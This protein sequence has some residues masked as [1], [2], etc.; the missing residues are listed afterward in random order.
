MAF[1]VVEVKVVNL[2]VLQTAKIFDIIE[3]DSALGDGVSAA[4]VQYADA[5]NV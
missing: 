1:H 3:L 5:V 4:H 2:T